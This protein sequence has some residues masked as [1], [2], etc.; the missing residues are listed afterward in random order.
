VVHK[1][2]LLALVHGDD[3]QGLKA[4]S[5]AVEGQVS[6]GCRLSTAVSRVCLSLLGHGD[7][8]EGTMVALTAL[9]KKAEE[10]SDGCG[11]ERRERFT[12]KSGCGRMRW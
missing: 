11:R 9:L 7:E 8:A 5:V 3:E 2:E 4:R 12:A 10:A 6:G 1:D